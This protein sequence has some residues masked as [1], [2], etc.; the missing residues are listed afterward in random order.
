MVSLFFARKGAHLITAFG[1]KRDVLLIAWSFCTGEEEEL[2]KGG[3]G[4]LSR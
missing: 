1:D 3:G 2:F 4:P